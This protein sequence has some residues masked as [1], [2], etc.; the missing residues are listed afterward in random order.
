MKLK[1]GQY[2]D[3]AAWLRLGSLILVEILNL[4]LVKILKFEFSQNADV[5]LGF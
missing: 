5:W 2:F 3:A 1:F 4:G